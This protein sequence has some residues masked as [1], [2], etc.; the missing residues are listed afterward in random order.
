MK[1]RR[2]GGFAEFLQGFN[3]GY[4]TVGKV[5]SDKDVV[6]MDGWRPAPAQKVIPIKATSC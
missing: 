1:R 4:E 2:R 3:Q 6:S 5:L